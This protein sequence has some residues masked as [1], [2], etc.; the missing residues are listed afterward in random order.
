MWLKPSVVEEK[1]KKKIGKHKPANTIDLNNVPILP[2]LL[3]YEQLK[4]LNGALVRSKND[5]RLSKKNKYL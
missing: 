3:S 1:K 2:C 5:R 4:T